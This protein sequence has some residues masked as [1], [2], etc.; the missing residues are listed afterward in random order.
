M[1]MSYDMSVLP[2][3]NLHLD[4]SYNEWIRPLLDVVD[5]LRNLGVMKEGIQLP[6][7][8]VVGDQSS[9]KSSVLESLAGISL[10]K[11]QGICTR[12]PLIM[13]LQ[14]CKSQE[15][16]ITIE[17]NGI[18]RSISEAQ[19]TEALN[20]A[21]EEIAG[22][23][24][25]ISDT[26]ITLNVSKFNAPDLTMVD[27]PGITRVPVHGQPKD[28]YEQ[29]A[30]VIK[31]YITPKESIIL[32]VLSASVDFPTCESI[33]MSQ[34]VDEKG[35][36]TL[37]VVTKVDKAA[38]GLLEKVTVDAVNIGLG[39][40]CVR[41]RIGNESNA[42]ARQI[43]RELFTKDPHLSKI[44]KSMVGIPVLAEKLMQIQAMGI[45]KCLPEIVRKI[46]ITLSKRQAELNSL[47][48]NF[49]SSVEAMIEF[50]RLMDSIKG[51]LHKLL[52]QGDTENFQDEPEMN[53]IA[54]LTRMFKSFS[55]DLL[56]ANDKLT[57]NFLVEEVKL[58]EEAQGLNLPN[59]LPH[60]VFVTL[61]QTR[62][63]SFSERSRGLALQTCD[64]LD[65]VICRV[66]D[67]QTEC[68]PQ[69]QS[70]SRRAFQA[71]MD[72]KKDECV[73]YVEDVMEMHKTVIYTENPV[74]TEY[75]QRMHEFK[76]RFMEAIQ[77]NHRAVKIEGMGEIDLK[78]VPKTSDRLGAAFEMKM[79]LMAYWSVVRIRLADDIPLH[80]RFVFQ[81]MVQNDVVG[82]IVKEVMGEDSTK[83]GNILEE[84]SAIANR[85]RSLIKSVN[86]L[87]ESKSL[88]SRT[89]GKIV[90]A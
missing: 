40:V 67:L 6:S 84:S 29:I 47:P 65:K 27:L 1:D 16:Q 81:K 31:Q 72:M 82:C 43:E 14:S 66:I 33:R 36:R 41:N 37:A 68:Y 61:L 4:K 56:A 28:I 30:R 64:Y 89:I 60:S 23:G 7:I 53:C 62:I 24:K 59:F 42:Q 50:M 83:I 35:E 2:P 8:V 70:A 19:I 87:R 51:I 22:T 49:S 55:R 26:P 34:Q 54:H 10:P 58:L 77:E 57:E 88:L 11:G 86:L 38:E 20:V 73:H 17:Y 52:I 85:R 13:R 76:K 75:L 32:N 90:E 15:T 3:D 48:R 46:D 45:K 63:D 44:D 71:L 9:G 78:K 18:T 21:T 39:Y 79:S 5:K 69:L 74:Y 80:L 25:G 12:V